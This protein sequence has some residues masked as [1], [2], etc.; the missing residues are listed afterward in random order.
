MLLLAH[1]SFEF[2]GFILKVN[3]PSPGLLV[4]IIF[5][6][7]FEAFQLDLWQNESPAKTP[8]YMFKIISEI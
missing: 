4:A 6:H 5:W 1:L 8:Q 3:L 7:S 2:S